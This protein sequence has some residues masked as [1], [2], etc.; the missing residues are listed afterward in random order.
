MNIYNRIFATA[1]MGAVAFLA[2]LLGGVLTVPA[3]AQAQTEMLCPLHSDI[4][5]TIVNSAEQSLQKIHTTEVRVSNQ[6]PQYLPGVR[7]GIALFSKNDLVTPKFWRVTNESYLLA[8]ASEISVLLESEVSKVPAGEY[9]LKAFAFQGSE[10]DLL[11]I[12]MRDAEQVT[13]VTFKKTAAAETEVSFLVSIDNVPTQNEKMMSF[14]DLP[15]FKVETKNLGKTPIF[16]TTLLHVVTQGKIPL[17]GAVLR[18]VSDKT[19]LL[20]QFARINEFSTQPYGFAASGLLI[21]TLIDSTGFA[22]IKIIDLSISNEGE[23]ASWLYFS[24][25]G[26]SQYP[27]TEEDQIVSCVSYIGPW[28]ELNY[29]P[30]SLSTSIEISNQ[31]Q[32]LYSE[33]IF[34]EQDRKKYFSFRPELVAG[35]FDIT[36]ALSQKRLNSIYLDGDASSAQS[37]IKNGLTLSDRKTFSL[38]CEE[39]WCQSIVATREVGEEK[40]LVANHVRSFWFYAGIVI[41]AALLMYLMLRRL[42][43]VAPTNKAGRVNPEELQ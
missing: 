23:E 2:V 15:Q 10:A 7:V 24:R 11:G 21:A 43:P 20:P 22:P 5:A 34:N 3:P 14:G 40:E 38:V 19:T 27:L 32:T 39:E 35:T 31:K 28:E 1:L 37:D 13:G 25:I 17:G 8:P 36:L 16:D 9:V 18:S 26:F 12:I 6:N 42:D 30:E 41:A 33:S 29:V 4:Q